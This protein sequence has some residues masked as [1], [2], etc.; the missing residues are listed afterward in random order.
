MSFR[1]GIPYTPAVNIRTP[2]YLFAATRPNL[3]PGR[4]NN[5]TE[6]VS[7][8]CPGIPA[9][10]K[11]QAPDLYF[12]PCAFSPPPPGTLGNVGRNTIIAPNVFTMDLSLQREF[13]LDA[14]RRFQFRAEFFNLPNHT[15]FNRNV[16]TSTVIF[17]GA[18]GSLSPAVARI[19]STAS[20]ARQIQFA[21]RVS[22]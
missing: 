5:P 20:T 10:R 14:K 8:G 13:V 22:F 1:S 12:D 2:G 18:S 16:G 11:L 3:V 6:G 21:L 9:G 15:N 7:A 19:G 17:S 4:S